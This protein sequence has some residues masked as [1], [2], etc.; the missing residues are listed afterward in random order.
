MNDSN[1]SLIISLNSAVR[2]SAVLYG[3][4][5]GRLQLV[6]CLNSSAWSLVSNPIALEIRDM[7]PE[8]WLYK[9]IMCVD[10]T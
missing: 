7:D 6:I 2:N 5:C 10:L 8:A 3:I 1:K 9:I 4:K